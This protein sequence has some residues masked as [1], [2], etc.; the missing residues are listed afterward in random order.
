MNSLYEVFETNHDTCPIQLF[1]ILAITNNE[2]ERK[3][4]VYNL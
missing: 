4:E 2:K 3:K 1:R